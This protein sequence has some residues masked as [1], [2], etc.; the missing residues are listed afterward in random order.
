MFVFGGGIDC[1]Q[2]PQGYAAN[3]PKKYVLDDEE[4]A[5][6]SALAQLQLDD[7]KE[8]AEEISDVEKEKTYPPYLGRFVNCSEEKD[9]EDDLKAYN[10]DNYDDDEV[11][12][13]DTEPAE[14][15]I[16]SN[17]KGL[18]Y[19]SSNEEDPYITLK[20]VSSLNPSL[21]IRRVRF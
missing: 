15:G 8:E 7:A 2:V 16:F 21:G 17:V 5:R 20:D 3:Q 18:S 12:D 14:L 9:E 10:L 19:Y 6:I 1:C 4:Y 11:G 13:S